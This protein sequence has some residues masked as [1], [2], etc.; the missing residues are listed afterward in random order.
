MKAKTLYKIFFAV[1][2]AIIGLFGCSVTTPDPAP[3]PHVPAPSQIVVSGT[4]NTDNGRSATVDFSKQNL[5]WYVIAT[6]NEKYQPSATDP[7][8]DVNNGKFTL[9]LPEA[10]NWVIYAGGFSAQPNDTYTNYVI[11]GMTEKITVPKSGVSN[12]TITA[13]PRINGRESGSVSLS[14]KD[15]SEQ[16]AKVCIK[17]TYP[18]NDKEVTFTNGSA[19]LTYGSVLATSYPVTLLFNDDLGNTLYR[20]KEVINVIQDCTTDTWSGNSTY[21]ATE[22]GKKILTVTLEM[23]EA[24][25]T[26]CV[27][28]TDVVVYDNWCDEEY[29]TTH[30]YYFS[31]ISS[32]IIDESWG[33]GNDSDMPPISFTFDKAGNLYV[34]NKSGENPETGDLYTEIKTNFDSAEAKTITFSDIDFKSITIDRKTNTLYGSSFYSDAESPM[35]NLYAYPTIISANNTDGMIHYVVQDPI[36]NYY[37]DIFAINDGKVY[38]PCLTSNEE[39]Q[40]VNYN[41]IL[42]KATLSSDDANKVESQDGDPYYKTSVIDKIEIKI[43]DVTL[44]STMQLTDCLYQDGCVYMLLRESRT[45][46]DAEDPNMYSRGAV[47]KYDCFDGSIKTLGWSDDSIKNTEIKKM[48]LY[49]YDSESEY[50]CDLTGDSNDQMESNSN[51]NKWNQ[52]FPNIYAPKVDS[53]NNPS[54]NCFYGPIKFVGIKPKKLVIADDGVAIYTDNDALKFKNVNRIV[55]ID[56]EN[57]AISVD[58]NCSSYFNEDQSRLKGNDICAIYQTSDTAYFGFGIP[59]ADD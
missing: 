44:D 30:K 24:Y 8:A 41:I 28:N 23:V 45:Y 39:T 48:S 22:N 40:V 36:L 51:Y 42:V 56:L 58:P 33:E 38:I 18:L 21:F 9:T 43:N 10:G 17:G 34:L 3:A 31:N 1:L 47:I 19:T 46:W 13:S 12:L 29:R 50:I 49:N 7:T 37:G 57:F 5:T 25:G 6:Q 4:I 55:T 54:S 26:E 11:G 59:N 27:P 52:L 15:E 20:C 53:S 2:C 35:L 16:L 32:P 14:F